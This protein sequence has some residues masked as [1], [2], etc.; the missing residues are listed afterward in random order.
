[1]PSLQ[2][3]V[4]IG[5]GSFASVYKGE[6]GDDRRAVAVKSVLRAKLNKKLLENLETEIAIMKEM[7]KHPHIVSLI[8]YQ[9]TNTHFHLVM[10]YCALGDLS[11]FIRKRDQISS[12]LPL[13]ASLF[14][15][16][17]SQGQGGGLNEQ[18]ARHFLKQLASAL[19]FLRSKNLVH[20]DIKPQNLLLC[21]PATS[22]DEAVELGYT[23][24]LW[25]LPVLKLADFGFARILP[26]TSLAETLCGSPLYM[27]PEILRYEKYGAKADLWSVG[28]VLYEMVVGKPPFKAANHM[29]LLKRIEKTNDRIKIP[30]HVVN[31]T[32]AEIRRLIKGLL[33]KSPTE[34]MSF[35]E[36][37]GDPVLK[38]DIE[39]K[40]TPLDRSR[41]D[42]NLFISE[43][44]QQSST[45]KQQQQQQPPPSSS[46]P[47]QQQHKAKDQQQL[48]QQQQLVVPTNR[49]PQPPASSSSMDQEYVVVEKRTVEVNALADELAQ[50]PTN[51]NTH[52]SSPEERRVT[53]RRSSS[54]NYPGAER[55]PSIGY[56]TSPT[57]ALARA[58]SMASARLFGTKIDPFNST[59][60]Y[61]TAIT[62][63]QQTNIPTSIDG[64][65]RKLIKYLDDLTTKAKVVN[66]FAEV[67]FSQ[68]VPT[69]SAAAAAPSEEEEDDV[70][71]SP[72]TVQILAEEALVLYVKMLSLLAKAM[73][74]AAHWWH[75][76]G[77][78]TG[79]SL[80]L[81]DT[82]QW[83]RNKFN[84][85]LEKAEFAQ[86]LL[87]D[88]QSKVAES[89][90]SSSR[91]QQTTAE[92]LIFDR[93]LEMS[94]A[95]A[96]S[97]LDGR[98]LEGCELS[99]GTAVW[100]LE[101]LLEPTEDGELEEDDKQLV[102]KFITSIG[103]RLSSLRKKLEHTPTTHHQ[104]T[105]S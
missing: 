60:G 8:D 29:E 17:P 85:S 34:R 77:E 56:G 11:Y 89:S 84:E 63:P 52:A 102:S 43:Y 2:I 15:R 49:K 80:R 50:S 72:E 96:V 37:F 35:N 103:D 7:S 100:M 3:G 33:K 71:L 54:P 39:T 74:R 46:P 42:Q 79:A 92:K 76:N 23:E 27:A 21:P 82:V 61:S 26:S 75:V 53:R 44:V 70:Q 19:S 32:S 13:V 97:E 66:I 22:H 24:G 31:H 38:A 88:A 41:L 67:K 95:A 10:E 1:M 57:S 68:I 81:N 36:F 51:P 48:Q 9:Q 87:E 99:Y 14:E 65:E 94:R 62:V 78:S 25:E 69:A 101:A 20:R 59:G 105:Q 12:S 58:L 45:R 6:Y 55:R 91:K 73:D 47:Q 4:E 5:R 104:L 86:T 93:A 83:I 30:E 98:D 28:A 64:D 40:N 90:S 18:L 16:Y